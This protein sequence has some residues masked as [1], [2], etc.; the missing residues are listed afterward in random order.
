MKINSFV[1]SI[2]AKATSITFIKYFLVGGT[3]AL[4]ELTLFYTLLERLDLKIVIA[5]SIAYT[6]LFFFNYILQRKWAFASK[7]KVKKQIIAY[8][9][10]FFFN[11]N[12]SNAMVVFLINGFQINSLVSKFLSMGLFVPLNFLIYRNLIF[13]R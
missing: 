8:G 9:L 5:N 4:L 2:L 1:K 6:T 13:K 10:L 7:M 3:S 11:L 12:F